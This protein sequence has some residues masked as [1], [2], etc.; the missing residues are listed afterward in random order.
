MKK[1][2]TPEERHVIIDKGTEAPFSGKY[3][4]FDADGT[5]HCKQCGAP[6]YRSA[7]KFDS[8]CGWPSFDD[9][10]PGAVRRTPDP[11]GQ[12]T[13]ITCARCGAH[14]GHVFTG[15]GFTPKDTRHCVNSISLEFEPAAP[16]STAEAIF[17]GGCFW[18]VEHLMQQQAGV[19][20][21]ES[22][23]IGGTT[24]HPTYEQVC[25]Q[26]TGH[27]EAVRVTYDPTKI[28]YETLA[29][30][31]FEIHDPTQQDGQGPDLGPQYRSEIFYLDSE[32]KTIAER[33]IRQLEAKGYRI[34]TRV[35]P[36]TVFW[37]AETYH[38]DYY[39]RKGTEPYCHAYTKRF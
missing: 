25:T 3:V 39:R 6:L 23:Y 11:D 28:D 18:G 12:R 32:Q 30:R 4:T 17:A 16:A 29:K 27:A 24:D 31:F 19:I 8:G 2:L 1:D 10:L 13:E 9:A 15:E 36:A 38:Q 22:G 33:L 7:D 20:S 37:P 14:L 26:K 34:A 21:V 35:T 5:Y